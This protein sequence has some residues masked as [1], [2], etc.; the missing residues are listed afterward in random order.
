MSHE[1]DRCFQCQE[2]GHI[3]HHCPNVHCFECEEY[4]HIVVDCPHWIPPSGTPAHHH[5]QD[6]NTRHC[7]RS[8]SRHHH[9]DRY[10]NSR[11]RSQSHPHRYCSHSHQDSHRGHSRSHHRDSRVDATIG[12]LHM[13]P[14]PSAYCFCHDTPH[15]RSSSHR[16]S[17]TH[18]K[19][20]SRSQ[21]CSAYKPSKKTLY[22]S[23]SSPS[24]LQKS[25]DRRHPRVR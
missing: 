20:C 24:K 8:T 23:S 16:S 5:R 13:M 1:E 7:T 12:V 15:W 2:L 25:Q 17:S 4:G 22:K 11:S 3:A 18:S 21:S 14:S 10:R 9:Q 6:S 19:D